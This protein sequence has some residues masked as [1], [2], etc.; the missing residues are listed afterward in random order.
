MELAVML[1]CLH[2]SDR[3]A[4]TT[5]GITR[6]AAR[7]SCLRVLTASLQLTHEWPALVQVR[8]KVEEIAAQLKRENGAANGVAAF[9]RHAQLS[10]RQSAQLSLQYSAQLSLQSS[11]Q[12]SLL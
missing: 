6:L 3:H 4:R 8:Q 2:A 1:A 12:L 5:A 7:C 9:H 11:A 10:L